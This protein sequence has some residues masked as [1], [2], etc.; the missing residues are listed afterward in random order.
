MTTVMSNECRP[1]SNAIVIQLP[2]KRAQKSLPQPLFAAHTVKKTS[3][4]LFRF[5]IQEKWAIFSAI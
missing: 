3:V 2:Q 5:G 4:C 1:I